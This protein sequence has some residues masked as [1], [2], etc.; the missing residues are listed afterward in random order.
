MVCQMRCQWHVDRVLLNLPTQ[1][2]PPTGG[3]CATCCESKLTNSIELT[4]LL[5]SLGRQQL[6]LWTQM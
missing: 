2:T 3:E 6:E 4:K 1:A 5:T